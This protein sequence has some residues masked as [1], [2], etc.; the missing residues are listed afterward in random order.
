MNKSTRTILMIVLSL[1]IVINIGSY[2][3]AIFMVTSLFTH[4]VEK[5]SSTP[6]ELDLFGELVYFASEDQVPLAAWYIPHPTPHAVVIVLHG[7]DGTDASTFLPH[8][9]FLHEAGYSSLVLDMR[10]HGNSGGDRIGLAFEEPLDAAAAVDWVK[11][12]P[13][14]MEKPVV[15]FGIS[16]GGAVAIRTA[17]ARPEVA[18]VISSSAYASIDRMIAQGMRM[19]GS[20]EWMITIFGP[21]S[22]LA[23]RTLY[24][25]WPAQASPLHDIAQIAPRPVFILHGDSDSQI[26]VENAYNLAAAGGENVEL[27]IAEGADHFVFTGDGY[28]PED[29]VYR[30]KVLDFLARVME[31]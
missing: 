13:E 5:F 15:L 29:T 9:K 3:G 31:E 14:I 6:Q 7:M 23:M 26:P 28:G 18:A 10:A 8:A 11:S 27:W 4:R 21:Y 25:V 12:Q 19:M 24:G 16:M 30:G 17:A 2:G 22:Q 20:P 1:L